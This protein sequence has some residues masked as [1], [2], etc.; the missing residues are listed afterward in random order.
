MW[1]LLCAV[2]ALIIC[3]G[4]EHQEVYCENNVGFSKHQGDNITLKWFAPE[5]TPFQLTFTLME[6]G[7]KCCYDSSNGTECSELQPEWKTRAKR[8]PDLPKSVG[9]GAGPNNFVTLNIG[10][11]SQINEGHYNAQIGSSSLGGCYI[12]LTELLVLGIGEFIAILLGVIFLTVTFVIAIGYILYG[13]WK[14]QN[15][16]ADPGPNRGSDRSEELREPILGRNEI[17]T[18]SV[19]TQT[20]ENRV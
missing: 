11:F 15:G 9:K 12:V 19:T 16:R 14:R 5:A 7:L 10:M 20:I 17:Q 2:G 4:G 6:T 3:V 13:K 18:E 1:P 8:C